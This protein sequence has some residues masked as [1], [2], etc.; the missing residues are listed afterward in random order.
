MLP[1]ATELY[2]AARHRALRRRS[3]E[4][5]TLPLA[6]ELYVAAC[7]RALHRR[8]PQSSTSLLAIVYSWLLLITAGLLAISLSTAGSNCSQL[9]AWPSHCLQPAPT[10]HSCPPGH[11]I[12]WPSPTDHSWPTG[13]LIVYSRLQLLTAVRLTM[14]LSTAASYRPQ[15]ASLSTARCYTSGLLAIPLFT[16]GSYCSQL[17]SWPSQCLQANSF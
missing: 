15:L 8:S 4:S 17:A 16:A 6:T 10:A 14:S 1:L 12:V 9:S 11:L 5:S 7:H 13:L 2:V 3:P